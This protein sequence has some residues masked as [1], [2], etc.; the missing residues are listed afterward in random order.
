MLASPSPGPVWVAAGDEAVDGHGQVG[1]DV[2]HENP[3]PEIA[4]GLQQS[5][6]TGE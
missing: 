5:T 3:Y 4:Q 2:V 1:E 6:A